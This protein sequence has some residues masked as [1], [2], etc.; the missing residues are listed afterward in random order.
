MGFKG[1]RVNLGVGN[2]FVQGFMEIACRAVIYIYTHN[3]E[4]GYSILSYQTLNIQSLF[5]DLVNTR[6]STRNL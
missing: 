6:H 2:R 4:Y 1:L 5:E 3:A